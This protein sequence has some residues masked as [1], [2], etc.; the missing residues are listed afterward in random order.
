MQFW[1]L[2]GFH[3]KTFLSPLVKCVGKF[4]YVHIQIKVYPV[5][6]AY[7]PLVQCHNSLHYASFMLFL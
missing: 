3:N 6:L 4:I 1:G 7:F 2:S 5:I